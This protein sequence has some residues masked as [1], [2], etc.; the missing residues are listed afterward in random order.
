[1]IKQRTVIITGMHRSGTSLVSS[2]LQT[3]GVNIGNSLL[4]AWQGNPR[5]HFE[6]V[7]FYNFHEKIL[8]RLGQTLLVQSP[9]TLGEITAT[10]TE[11][12]LALI[13]QRRHHHIWGWKDPRTSLFLPFWHKLLPEACYIFIYRHPLEVT[14]SLLRRGTELETLANPFIGLRAWQVYNHSILNFY[15]QYSEACLLCHISSVVIDI[16]AFIDLIAKK[17]GVTLPAEGLQN[18]YHNTELTQIEAAS[19]PEV[20]S[21]LTK[22][23]PEAMELY[24]QLQAQADLPDT[25]SGLVTAQHH[26]QLV[27][28]LD[29]ASDLRFNNEL[30]EAVTSPLFSLL[31]TMLDP[32]LSLETPKKIQ[33]QI[34]EQ[35]TQ[36]RILESKLNNIYQTRSWQL[37]CKYWALKENGLTIASNIYRAT[38][39][40]QVPN[41]F[42]YFRHTEKNAAPRTIA[43]SPNAISQEATKNIIFVLPGGLSLSGV[44]TWSVEMCRR[45]VRLGKPTALVEHSNYNPKLDIDLPPKVHLVRCTDQIYPTILHLTE[46]HL[47]GYIPAY[48]GVLPGIII[49]NWSFGTY[50][51]C[52][53]IATDQPEALRIIGFA[54][55]DEADYYEWLAY[56]EPIIHRFVA[57]SQEIA[58]NLTKILPHREQD[59]IVRP[60]AIDIPPSLNRNYSPAQEP[61]KLI[62]AGRISE[63]QKRISDLLN[64]V[65]VL[66]KEQVNFQLRIIGDGRDKEILRRKIDL[67]DQEIQ[68]R[69]KLEGCL[70]PDQMPDVWQSADIFILVSEYEGTSIAMLEAMAQ[71]CVPVVTRVSG[72]AAVV[73]HKMDGFS[74]PVGDIGGMA[75]IIKVLDNDRQKLATLGARAQATIAVRFAYDEYIEWFQ[76]MVAEVWQQPPRP[77]PA[78]RPLLPSRLAPEQPQLYREVIA[79]LSGQEIARYILIRRIIQAIGFKIAAQPG[80]GWLHRYRGFGKKMLGDN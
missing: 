58:T 73:Q 16:E 17:F 1:M 67:L 31:L 28:L 79:G 72:V 44:T 66:Q 7:D 70:S 59:I 63:R 37:V 24:A 23:V 40:Q 50:A 60:Y 74:V 19:A 62:Y 45:L 56:Y 15:R 22:V 30:K 61:L 68:Q 48:R 47:A 65:E 52:A 33:A 43:R 4:G 5:G 54:H 39:I 75:Q 26:Q 80:F 69:I 41:L 55:A 6:D 25:A 29:F 13:K 76:S 9:A 14:F 2:L 38:G 8:H 18:L 10:E 20:T 57:V 64:L 35:A 34:K 11:E 71:G 78:K 77:W 49:P 12:A 32:Q 21:V 27:D 42:R 36:V 53:S 46:D 51:T 3:A